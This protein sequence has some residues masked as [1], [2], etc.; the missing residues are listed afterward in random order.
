MLAGSGCWVRA[1]LAPIACSSCTSV[2]S[3]AGPGAS[4]WPG[5]SNW[6]EAPCSVKRL[7]VEVH[8]P[9]APRELAQADVRGVA[10]LARDVECQFVEAGA[11]G[12]PQCRRGHR[13]GGG[14]R[15]RLFGTDE[16]RGEG[17]GDRLPGA[18]E[19]AFGREHARQPVVVNG[20]AQLH[21]R[22]C[23]GG[24]IGRE[25]RLDRGVGQ[26]AGGELAHADRAVEAAEV[27]PCAVEAF[28]GLQQRVVPVHAHHQRVR[29]RPQRVA[30]FEGQ[31][32]TDVGAQR[33]TVDPHFDEVVGGREF[34]R[35]D[36]RGGRGERRAV[37][38]DRAFE[39]GDR[40]LAFDRGGVDHVGDAHRRAPEVASG[41]SPQLPDVFRV[42]AQRPLGERHAPAWPF[43]EFDLADAAVRA[44]ALG[45][46]GAAVRAVA[47]GLAGTAVRAVETGTAGRR[48]D[49]QRQ[50][51]GE[52]CDRSL[53]GDAFGHALSIVTGTPVRSAG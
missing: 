12:C 30:E 41:P 48:G 14:H 1:V 8:L 4:P 45:L 27:E 2:S 42:A 47:F 7:P 43:T 17:H 10:A 37:P 22:L 33:V 52:T 13:E 3:S 49:R 32:E 24:G 11:S 50:Q 29:A 44:V 28:V 5:A 36:A 46:A 34:Q 16:L 40:P 25:R 23:R 6:I 19:R 51:H 21:G 26:F 9:P 38:R 53:A 31:V 18:T 39:V 35:V 20:D 15:H